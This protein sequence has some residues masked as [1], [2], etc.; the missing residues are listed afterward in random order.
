MQ[1]NKIKIFIGQFVCKDSLTY[2]ERLTLELRKK[3]DKKLA[4][5]IVLFLMIENCVGIT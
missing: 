4:Q 2:I 5:N 1:L 3:R